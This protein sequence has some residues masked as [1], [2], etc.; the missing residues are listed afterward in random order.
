MPITHP[1]NA[2]KKKPSGVAGQGTQ[3]KHM[4]CLSEPTASDKFQREENYFQKNQFNPQFPTV[5]QQ[6]QRKLVY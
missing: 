6:S 1:W 2:G 3:G 5:H 4:E